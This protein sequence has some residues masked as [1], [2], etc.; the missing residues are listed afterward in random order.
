MSRLTCKPCASDNVQRFPTEIAIHFPYLKNIDRPHV[1][2][3]PELLVC[4]NCG[5]AEFAI[6]EAEVRVLGGCT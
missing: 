3:F 2:L 1:F 6:P 5:I 4:L